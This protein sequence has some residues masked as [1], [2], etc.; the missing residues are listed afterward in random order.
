MEGGASGA[1]IEG[2]RLGASGRDPSETFLPWSLMSPNS[3]KG[4]DTCKDVVDAIE[5]FHELCCCRPFIAHGPKSL[6]PYAPY[7]P[8]AS[9]PCFRDCWTVVFA[10]TRYQTAGN[11]ILLHRARIFSGRIRHCV[12]FASYPACGE[13]CLAGIFRKLHIRKRFA[14]VPVRMHGEAGCG[15]AP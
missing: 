1:K 9:G 10:F 7:A 2:A 8:Y 15:F 13:R 14:A 12:G 6:R 11:S 3:E 4:F 5:F